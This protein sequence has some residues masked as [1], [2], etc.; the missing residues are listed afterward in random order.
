MAF[1]NGRFPLD[2][3]AEIPGG[4][5][6]KEAA[7]SWNDM[8]ATVIRQ[9][10]PALMPLGSI[11]SYRDFAGQEK[12][13]THWCSQGHC[14]K[15]AV[16]GHSNHGWGNAVDA[17]TPPMWQWLLRLGPQFGWSHAEGARVKEAW[18]FTYVGGYRGD[19]YRVLTSTERGWIEELERHPRPGRQRELER[20]L[21]VQLHV[22]A[23]AA[24]KEGWNDKH[25]R[26]R[27]RILRRHL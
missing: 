10:G 19:P 26:D 17:A 12:M 13:R 8:R 21:R 16:P 5:L 4:H 1:E 22:I 14:E 2:E 18:H 3:L 25:R 9:G 7:R 11:S 6:S 15:A 24:A 23:V 20:K 27:Y